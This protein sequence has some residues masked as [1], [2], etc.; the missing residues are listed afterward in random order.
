MAQLNRVKNIAAAA[1]A[2]TVV[3]TG[4]VRTQAAP[5]MAPKPATQRCF[6]ITMVDDEPIA[7]RQPDIFDQDYEADPA[8]EARVDDAIETRLALTREQPDDLQV[9][10]FPSV[11][12][13][14]R[15]SDGFVFNTG[16]GIHK[17]T[18]EPGSQAS[19]DR[20][21]ARIRQLVHPG[22]KEAHFAC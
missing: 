5:M 1:I 8:L 22:F 12:E 9:E 19:C 11:V 7:C 20:V 13:W 21:N 4:A 6:N 2:A 3:A 10:P 18:H 16:R 14:S 15:C 17:I